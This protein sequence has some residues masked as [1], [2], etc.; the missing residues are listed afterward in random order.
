ME[1]SANGCGCGRVRVGGERG[2]WRQHP[3]SRGDEPCGPVPDRDL[4]AWLVRGGR[5]TFSRLCPGL[6]ESEQGVDQVVPKPD[7]ATGLLRLGWPVTDTIP[8]APDWVSG[9]YYLDVLLAGGTDVGIVR[10]VPV[11]V[12]ASPARHSQILAQASVIPWQAYNGWGGVSLY[13]KYGRGE[14]SHVSFDRPAV[15]GVETARR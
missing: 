7:P 5:R 2:A 6:S 1:S 4:P 12:L 3:S 15:G 14:G 11:I 8:I 9:Y 13:S 10:H